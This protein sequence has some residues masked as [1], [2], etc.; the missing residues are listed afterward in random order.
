MRLLFIL[1]L[2]LDHRVWA[3]LSSES[4]SLLRTITSLSN[5]VPEMI[6]LAMRS[7]RASD[8][9]HQRQKRFV[10]PEIL[11]KSVNV[12]PRGSLMEQMIANTISDVNFTSVA[13]LMLQNNDTMNKVQ[14]NI[15]MDLILRTLLRG[16]DQEKL[17]MG[18]WHAASKEFDLEHFISNIIN[19]TQ[20]DT[21]HEQLMSNGTLP[22]WVLKV[23]H[24]QLNNRILQGIFLTIKNVTMKFIRVIHQ[25]ERVDRYLF[26]MIIDQALTPINSVI[27]KVQQGKP[28]NFDQLLETL[29]SSANQAVLVRAIRS[30][31]LKFEGMTENIFL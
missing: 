18:I 9:L 11:L 10:S 24:P 6:Q 1:I 14:Q 27:R 2:C 7:Y 20:L 26:N 23:I 31:S 5:I 19:R 25:Y 22:E 17:A 8:S 12:N 4:C 28:K 13:L 29:A 3:Q 21:L 30:S 15:D 16:V